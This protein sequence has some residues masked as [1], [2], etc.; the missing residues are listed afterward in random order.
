MPRACVQRLCKRRGAV[1]Q[2]HHHG[3][4]RLR[5]PSPLPGGA[6]HGRARRRAR[7]SAPPLRGP[8][9]PWCRPAVSR[10][11]PPRGCAGKVLRAKR[12]VGRLPPKRHE[13]PQQ[14]AR[15]AAHARPC[16]RRGVP[17]RPP[18][19]PRR[20]SRP[21]HQRGDR[22]NVRGFKRSRH[23]QRAAPGHARHRERPEQVQRLAKVVQRGRQPGQDLL[24]RP[25][26]VP[27]AAQ[28]GRTFPLHGSR[29]ALLVDRTAARGPRCRLARRLGR[30]RLC[31]LAAPPEPATRQRPPETPL[32]PREALCP[33]YAGADVFAAADVPRPLPWG[34][35][36]ATARALPRG[37]HGYG[38][39]PCGLPRWPC[40]LMICRERVYSGVCVW[41]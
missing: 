8:S 5:Q 19:V 26:R 21:L 34:H 29:R 4:P 18:R 2:P 15:H 23:L 9:H 36:N 22:G 25:R 39:S 35:A 14:D 1:H 28:R 41:Y 37:P 24:L 38:L 12:A 3:P 40:A 6:Q 16:E 30:C 33:P 31:P 11:P 10:D 13:L 17:Q 7:R 20:P 27:R 32:G